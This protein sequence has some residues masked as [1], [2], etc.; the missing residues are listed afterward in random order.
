MS[1]SH[2]EEL[3]LSDLPVLIM[4]TSILLQV[5]LSRRRECLLTAMKLGFL[6]VDSGATIPRHFVC[7]DCPGQKSRTLAM[8]W[9]A[10]GIRDSFTLL[11]SWDYVGE[12][13]SCDDTVTINYFVNTFP[14]FCLGN[15]ETFP[16]CLDYL[17]DRYALTENN[18]V[19]N[20]KRK[21]E[22]SLVDSE[23]PDNNIL[24]HS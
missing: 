24:V 23:R 5:P 12:T 10:I 2:L 22:K 11:C 18:D 7:L 1:L 14:H 13:N 21:T 8:T 15:V 17:I 20:K 16:T 19:T 4:N 3:L 9:D 6:V